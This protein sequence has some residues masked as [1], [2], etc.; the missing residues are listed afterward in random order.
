V[1]NLFA[2]VFSCA[3]SAKNERIIRSDWMW[4]VRSIGVNT[5]PSPPF[6]H[7]W[8]GVYQMDEVLSISIS[9]CSCQ[10]PLYL[11]FLRIC[12]DIMKAYGGIQI[13]DSYNTCDPSSATFASFP[14]WVVWLLPNVL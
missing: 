13:R 5:E 10:Y 7:I 11:E 3:S 2:H 8:H 6:E 14:R 9:Q 12:G 4:M 1:V